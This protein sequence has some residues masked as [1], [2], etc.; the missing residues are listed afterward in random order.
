MSSSR[1]AALAMKLLPLLLPLC[2]ILQASALRVPTLAVTRPTPA[3]IHTRRRACCSATAATPASDSKEV[4]L[5]GAL[6]TPVAGAVM[7]RTENGAPTFVASGRACLD[8]YFDSVPGIGEE[9][10]KDLLGSA[11]AE[12]ATTT[13]RLIFQLGDPRKGKS[14]KP[15]FYR[16]MMWLW[17][18]HPE[19]FLQNLQLIPQHCYNKALLDLLQ[20]RAR[21]LSSRCSTINACVRSP[22]GAKIRHARRRTS[23]KCRST[24]REPRGK[25]GRAARAASAPTLL[26]YATVGDGGD[27]RA[28]LVS[29]ST[30][31]TRSKRSPRLPKR[32]GRS[33]APMQLKADARALYGSDPSFQSVCSMRP[34]TSVR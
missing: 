21:G 2:A 34:R 7:G 10:L 22:G 12:D 24:Y 1:L 6:F 20:A 18:H 30:Y 31:S 19:T 26:A 14:D 23:R 29:S 28:E 25:F 5:Y 4:D 8:L 27:R 15:N 16:A 17:Q 3:F 11:W 9:H 33:G 32:N 13:T